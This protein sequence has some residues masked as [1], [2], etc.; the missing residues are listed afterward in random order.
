[1]ISI[2]NGRKRA[3]GGETSEV[4]AQVGVKFREHLHYLR[5]AKLHVFLAISLHANEN[6]WAWPSV[7]L[8]A[9]ETGYNP[10]TIND[11]LK[12][13]CDLTINGERLLLKFQPKNKGNGQFHSNH[14]L[15]FP[16]AAEVEEYKDRGLHNTVS[17]LPSRENP[18]TGKPVDKEEPS[19]KVETTEHG[20]D[21][22]PADLSPAKQELTAQEAVGEAALDAAFGPRKT[23]KADSITSN[24]DWTKG[25][26]EPWR[27]WG[28]ES[29]ELDKQKS[30]YGPNAE[31]VLRLGHELDRALGL[32]PIWERPRKVKSWMSGIHACLLAAEWDA[33]LV[34]MTARKMRE[35][36]L[37]IKSPWS[38]EG[39]VA[40]AAAEKR[41][42]GAG[43][44]VFGR[45]Q[46]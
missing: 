8:L 41:S 26:P 5:G 13:L 4:F 18:V 37:T 34:L 42:G 45:L 29:A 19:S 11:A 32:R 23:P 40:A 24:G 46:V 14:Y 16:S 43:G 25:A 9:K 20:A 38:I 10:G 15:I 7:S 2:F 31:P 28:A 6:G 1:M 35:D 30:K 3:L 36:K 12:D 33:D 44:A 21:A 17:N 22:P 39:M 27:T